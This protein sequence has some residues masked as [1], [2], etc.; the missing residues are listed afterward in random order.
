VVVNEQRKGYGHACLAA[1]AR[2]PDDCTAVVFCDADGADDLQ[3][4]PELCR[5]VLEGSADLVI[6]SRV[7]GRSE[8]GAMTPPQVAGNFV[9]AA[10]IR[11]L[12]GARVTDLGP[13]RCVSRAA[14][15]RL[16]M[17]EK[18]YGWTVEMQ[19]KAFRLG[20]RVAE[21]AVDSRRRTAGRSKV[22]GRMI[23]VFRA[24]WGIIRTILH[25][26]RAP[27]MGAPRR[28]QRRRSRVRQLSPSLMPEVAA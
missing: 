21:M 1:M 4:L 13:F 28:R 6:G 18:T 25:Y 10:L 9:S 15:E 7:L 17:E 11:L 23:P 27:L 24:G 16:A 3:V 20:L 12:Y 14:L 8:P 5:P 26:T 19:V 22:S 2:L